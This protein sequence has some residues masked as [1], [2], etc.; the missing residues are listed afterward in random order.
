MFFFS[1]VVNPWYTPTDLAA[2]SAWSLYREDVI[3]WLCH[4]EKDGF[5]H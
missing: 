2:A 4:Y 3:K 1:Q 5:S